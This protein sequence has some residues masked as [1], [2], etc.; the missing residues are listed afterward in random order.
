MR[1]IGHFMK[2]FRSSF[3]KFPLSPLSL[4]LLLGGTLVFAAL[5]IPGV[6]PFGLPGFL[7]FLPIVLLASAYRPGWMFLLLVTLLP[8]EAANLASFPSGPDIRPYQLL[9]VSIF[10]GIAVR[11]LAGRSVPELPRPHPADFLLLLVP[12]GSLLSLMNASDPSSSLRFSVIRFSFFA[13]YAL[14][15]LYIRSSEDVS[16][17]FP[18]AVAS[19]SLVALESV[20]QNIFFLSGREAFE[21]MPGRP[22]GPFSEADWLGMFLV[23]SVSI[24]LASGY[25]VASRAGSVR[26]FF[27]A[28]RSRY[29]VS[30]LAFVLS[31]LIVTVSRSAWIGAAVSVMLAFA[32]AFFSGRRV[33]APFLLSTAISVVIALSAVMIVPLTDFDLSGR[34]GSVGSGLQTV[35]VSCENGSEIPVRIGTIDELPAFGCRHIDLGE[36]DTERAAGRMIAETERN[37]PNVSIRKRIYAESF[38]LAARHPFLGIGW[39]SVS[40]TLG[41]DDRGTDLNASDVFLEVWLGSGA[42]GLFGF[43]GFL[44][45]LAFRSLRDFF[46]T[47]GAFPFFVLVSFSG[48]IA[49]DVFNSGI[50]LGFFWALLGIAGSY[51]AEESEFAETI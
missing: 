30:V 37:D 35:T 43:S 6:V 5:R 24:L 50:L 36:I 21:A 34:A 49:F 25:V 45:L 13:L 44:L 41:T 47:R 23:L 3:P 16:R 33:I 19:V 27:R 2:K 29:L 39:G 4:R 9:V 32:L 48:M 15:R 28:K 1:K 18:F 22:N 46:R 10:F 31:A 40:A 12:L 42:L 20:V 51:L 8:I 17:I 7:I 26:S 38:A 14:F 11:A